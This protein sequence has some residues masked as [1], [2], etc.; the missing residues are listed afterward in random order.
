MIVQTS[1]VSAEGEP[2]RSEE[3]R[4]GKDVRRDGNL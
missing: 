4:N 3:K 2:V 1:Q